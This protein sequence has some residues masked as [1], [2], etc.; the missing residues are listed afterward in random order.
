MEKGEQVMEA[1]RFERGQALVLIILSIVAIFGFAA[2]AVD[3]GRIYAERRRAQS[4][5]DSA[6]LA[7]AYSAANS[8]SQD[9]DVI[10][11]I[12]LEKALASALKNGYDGVTNNTIIVNSPPDHGTYEECRCEYIQVVII[13]KV[14]PIFV[15][16]LGR[17]VSQITT[18]AVARGRHSQGISSGNAVHALI[19]NT[20]SG[21]GVEVDG[22]ITFKVNNGNIYSNKNGVKKGASGNVTVTGGKIITADGWSNTTGVTATGGFRSQDPLNVPVPPDPDCAIP[23][24]VVSGSTYNPGRY[25]G[26]TFGPGTFTMKPGMYCVSGD[27]RINA[28]SNV[29]GDGIFIVLLSGEIRINGNAKVNWKRPNNLVDGAGNQWGGMLI[30]LPPTN[31]NE[32][33]LTGD[34]G[35][36][37]SGTVFAPKALCE[38]GGNN[39]TTGSSAQLICHQVR[40]HGNPDITIDYHENED[41]QMAPIVELVE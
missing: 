2:L 24:G 34:N 37:F 6:A 25:N 35:T 23:A 7:A 10:Y 33:Y 31:T 11:N 16:L 12:A 22:N 27:I 40:L 4:A 14:D 13:S 30:Y 29:K 17:G 18:E 41:Y 36:K 38:Y 9:P 20:E 21:D 39:M 8:T 28:N 1:K 3:M 32:V 26:M 5:A 19:N 15:Q